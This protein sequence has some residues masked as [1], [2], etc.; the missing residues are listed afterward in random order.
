MNNRGVFIAVEG[1]DGVGKGTQAK[2]LKERLTQEGFSAELIAFPRYGHPAAK[3]VE[4]YLNGELGDPDTI[5]AKT[6]SLFYAN[7]R[8]DAAEDI[9]NLL[10]EGVQVIADRYVDSNAGHQGGKIEDPTQRE[11][12]L[13]WLYQLE[14]ED[15][16]IPK[17]DMVIIL[18]AHADISQEH[19]GKKDRREYLKE[20][21]HDGHEGN[22]EHLQRA[23]DSYLWLAER[24]PKRYRLINCSPDGEML[25]IEEIHELIWKEIAPL[26]A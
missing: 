8:L 17:P 21:T 6:A 12:Y 18:Y 5:D 25:S 2:R 13:A 23:S 16:N 26:V 7:D 22:I 19:V 1:I 3:D 24:D 9:R 10:S 15:N 20:G 4:R 14:Y 11:Q